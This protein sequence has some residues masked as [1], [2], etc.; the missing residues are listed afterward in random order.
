MH[1]MQIRNVVREAFRV[2]DSDGSG[3]IDAEELRQVIIIMMMKMVMIM[4]IMTIMMMMVQV[5]VNLGEKLSED[6]VEMMIKE[7]DT[8]G[9]G[10]VNYEEFINMMN[11]K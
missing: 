7:A 4:I 8:N 3:F 2:F 11:T 10:L 6:E 9:D 5:M 1:K